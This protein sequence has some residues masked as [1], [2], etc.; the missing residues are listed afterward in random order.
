M[1][2][3]IELRKQTEAALR[4][5]KDG[6]EIEIESRTSQLQQLTGNLLSAQ[7]DERKRIAR[8]LHDSTGQALAGLSMTISQMHK[9]ASGANLRR[10]EECRALIAT[11]SEIDG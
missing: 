1:E 2:R 5:V 11:A 6:L 3:E 7:D 9:D 4:E 8:E 10:F